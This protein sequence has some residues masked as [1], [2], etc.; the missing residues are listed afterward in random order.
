[1]NPLMRLFAAPLLWSLLLL[2]GCGPT[3]GGTGTGEL[4]IGPADFGAQPASV[5]VASIAAQLSCQ[6]TTTLPGEVP[7]PQGTAKVVFAGEAAS[8]PY[9]LTWEGNAVDLQSRCGPTHFEGEWGL[10]ASGESRAFGRFTGPDR[11]APQRAQLSVQ[12]VPGLAGT[13]DSLQVLVLD[14]DGRSLFGPLQ[15]RR[16]PAGPTDGPACP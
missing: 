2:S 15:L 12:A 10:L 8:G 14:A 11:G 7:Q 6:P 1:M 16:L 3:G 5:C 9:T 4:T 13:A